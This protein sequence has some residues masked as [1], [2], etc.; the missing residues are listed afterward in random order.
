MPGMPMTED[1]DTGIGI[2]INSELELKIVLIFF[3]HR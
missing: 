3:F 1:M 2:W